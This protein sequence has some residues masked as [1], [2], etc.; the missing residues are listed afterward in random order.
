MLL[1][2]AAFGLLYGPGLPEQG[3]YVTGKDTPTMISKIA[4]AHGSSRKVNNDAYLD[5]LMARRFSFVTADSAGTVYVFDGGNDL[6][7]LAP[8][9]LKLLRV[10]AASPVEVYHQMGQSPQRTTAAEI[11][12]INLSPKDRTA[13]AQEHEKTSQ[14]YFPKPE[15]RAGYQKFNPKAPVPAKG[16]WGAFK[17]QRAAAQTQ[18]QQAQQQRAKKPAPKT[19]WQRFWS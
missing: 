18:V 14:Q 11:F 10:N 3:Y 12:G 13:R 6:T 4:R 9:T 5:E 1:D 2:E 17:N 16:L 19:L 7:N 8:N 15:E